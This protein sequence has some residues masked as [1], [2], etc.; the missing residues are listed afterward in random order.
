MTEC[1][2]IREVIPD[3]TNRIGKMLETMQGIWRSVEKLDEALNGLHPKKTLGTGKDAS[4]DDGSIQIL[5]HMLDEL[6]TSINDVDMELREKL[7]LLLG[8]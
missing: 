3:L 7:M 6:Y 4:S 5:E 8:A 1:S 2:K